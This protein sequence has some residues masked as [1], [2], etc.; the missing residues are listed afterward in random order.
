MKK[1]ATKEEV[2]AY[3]QMLKNS[4]SETVEKEIPEKETVNKSVKN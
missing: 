4:K 2:E 1:K 3:L